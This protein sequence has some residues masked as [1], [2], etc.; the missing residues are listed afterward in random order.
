MAMAA[1]VIV[2][3]FALVFSFRDTVRS[4]AEFFDVRAIRLFLRRP[5][6]AA[7]TIA[8]VVGLFLL[9]WGLGS[10]RDDSLLL[11]LALIP[12][13]V[14]PGLALAWLILSDAWH[15]IRDKRKRDRRKR[16]HE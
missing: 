10:G 7:V 4:V 9:L 16:Y 5:W 14:A 3:V 6:R 1:I 8:V 15:A 2:L 12:L 13:I 11:F